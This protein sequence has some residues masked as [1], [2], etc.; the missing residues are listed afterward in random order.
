[1]LY[2]PA[3]VMSQPLYDLK[4]EDESIDEGERATDIL[5]YFFVTI[6]VYFLW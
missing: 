1:M 4:E 6:L 5:I 3:A 2:C